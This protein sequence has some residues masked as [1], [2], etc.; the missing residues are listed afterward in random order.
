MASR[1]EFGLSDRIRGFRLKRS[2][3]AFRL[4]PREEKFYA[5]FTPWRDKLVDGAAQL[6]R[7]LAS[8]PPDWEVA[9]DIRTIE[10]GC[11]TIAH[12]IF[13]RLNRTFVTPDR[14]RGHPRAGDL[15]RRR[16]GRHR[17]GG[18]RHPP[19]PRG[20]SAVRR[21]RA[22]AR[23]RPVDEHGPQGRPGARGEEGRARAGS[24]GQPP[25]ERGRP[26]PRRG[27]D[28]TCSTKRRIRSP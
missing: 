28:A 25:R 20:A 18:H 12:E 14:P 23:H 3:V 21:P 1:P 26:R 10:Q 4:I 11:D 27:A 22:G 2:A 16:D 15:A 17:R 19:L 8:E 13:Q 6:V 7:M 5:D 9:R 24:R